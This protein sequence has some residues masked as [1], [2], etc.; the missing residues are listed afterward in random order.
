MNSSIFLVKG[1]ICVFI[2]SYSKSRNK[3]NNS[4]FLSIF[5][6]ILL[7][8]LSGKMESIFKFYLKI[9]MRGIYKA[10]SLFSIPKILLYCNI[11]VIMFYINKYVL[12]HL[13]C[14]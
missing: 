12:T 5:H 1:M 14:V 8:Y 11:F 10:C 3:G 2:K 9:C 7:H 13:K 4:T 6:K